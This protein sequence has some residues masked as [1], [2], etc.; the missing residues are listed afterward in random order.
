MKK[1]IIAVIGL[2]LSAAVAVGIWFSVDKTE[3]RIDQQMQ[4]QY[5][6]GY[7]SR[8]D[9]IAELNAERAKQMAALNA[10]IADLQKQLDNT[11]DADEIATIKV[12]IA[13]LQQQV[14]EL[15]DG[16]TGGNNAATQSL[17]LHSITLR[18]SGATEERLRIYVD[19]LTTDATKLN[20]TDFIKEME[21]YKNKN[22]GY[23][24]V[25]ATGFLYG[26]PVGRI[27]HD[28]KDGFTVYFS[29]GDYMYKIIDDNLINIE[30]DVVTQIL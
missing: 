12:Q 30:S 2:V 15:Q 21:R 20:K 3:K 25:I 1:F 19:L 26:M 7:D 9:E 16:S 23:T 22:Y 27:T 28:Q 13:K 14:A 17:Y 6:A 29:G 18:E 8:D 11:A 24:G 5:Q 10:Q 4:E